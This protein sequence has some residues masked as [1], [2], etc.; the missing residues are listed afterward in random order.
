MKII[1]IFINLRFNL[2]FVFNNCIRLLNLYIKHHLQRT[3]ITALHVLAHLFFLTT[4]LWGK[5]YYQPYFT[6]QETDATWRAGRVKLGLKSGSF[7]LILLKQWFSNWSH[8]A[9]VI[10]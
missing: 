4:I 9:T 1:P 6:D 3:V 8:F 2:T 7:D 5:Y 10:S